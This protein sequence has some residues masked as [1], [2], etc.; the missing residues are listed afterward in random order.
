MRI[1]TINGMQ[2]PSVTTILEVIAKPE[3]MAWYKRLGF[4]E[5][6]RQLKAAGNHGTQ[7]HKLFEAMLEDPRGPHHT[8]NE[9]QEQLSLW[10][11]ANVAEVLATEMQVHSPE[12]RYAGRF[13]AVVK[14][15]NHRI[16]ILDLKTGRTAGY[17]GEAMQL[18]AYRRAAQE[19]L[20]LTIEDRM[21]LHLPRTDPDKFTIIPITSQSDADWTAFRAATYLWWHLNGSKL[22]AF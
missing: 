8:R 16:V 10:L 20:G 19:S 2:Y 17:P 7:Q 18:E 3:L 21:I 4:E 5:A 13:D 12:H 14:L 11:Q 6:E 9:G 22:S 1:Y 15:M